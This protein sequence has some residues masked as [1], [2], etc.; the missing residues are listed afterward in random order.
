MGK[1]WDW[2]VKP[3]T[4]IFAP[5]VEGEELISPGVSLKIGQKVPMFRP[6]TFDEYIGQDKAKQMIKS[7][8]EGVKQRNMP[9]PHTLIYGNAGCGK[10]TLARIM[11]KELNQQISELI[12]AEIKSSYD[13]IWKLKDFDGKAGVVFLDEIH[14]MDRDTVEGLYPMM[15]DF[16]HN[17]QQI[18]PFTMIGATTELGEI[19]KRS[20]PFVERF[21]LWIELEPYTNQNIVEIVTQYREH[22]FSKDAV[23]SDVL[24]IIGENA[25]CTPRTGIRLLEA[26]IYLGDIKQAL[27][28]ANVI[29]DGYTTRDLKC[30]SYLNENQKGVGLQGLSSYL[31]IPQELYVY[32]VEPYLLQ[33][34]MII[35]TPRG[36][37]ITALG[38]S[39]MEELRK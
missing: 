26:T 36:R 30:L 19:L 4:D 3:I 17:N 39:K 29:K 10:T 11:A 31:N 33:N 8:I 37:K 1:F 12:G 5:Y 38:I 18:V 35:R 22:L 24:S 15:E 14:A 13:I 20:R 25:R 23:S 16:K 6:E 28:N 27:R 32:E 7:Y 21:K 2:Y 9:F 34:N